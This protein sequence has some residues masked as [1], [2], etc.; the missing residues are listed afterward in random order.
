M[1]P[2]PVDRPIL[3]DKW[4]YNER[5]DVAAM[6]RAVAA[7]EHHTYAYDLPRT[8]GDAVHVNPATGA[9]VLGTDN[10]VGSSSGRKYLGEFFIPP[11]YTFARRLE[12]WVRGGVSSSAS[13]GAT[14]K[15][16]SRATGRVERA[17]ITYAQMNN[18]VAGWINFHIRAEPFDV[19]EVWI[20][21]NM[22][23]GTTAAVNG[24]VAWWEPLDGLR[25]DV[26]IPTTATALSQTYFDSADV[27]D[28][29]YQLRWLIRHANMFAGHRPR[30]VYTKWFGP[31]VATAPAGTGPVVSSSY[32]KVYV[33]DQISALWCRFLLSDTYTAPGY[34]LV[35]LYW[36]GTQVTYTNGSGWN[37]A[38]ISP[39]T[40]PG[41]NLNRGVHELRVDAVADAT[42]SGNAATCKAQTVYLEENGVS[43]IPLASGDAVPAGFQTIHD[44]AFASGLPMRR[45]I[46]ASGALAGPKALI[47]N[48][49]WLWSNRY[50]RSLVSDCRYHDGPG[51]G[52]Y[53]ITPLAGAQQMA[54]YAFQTAAALR[55]LGVYVHA[56]RTS[57]AGRAAPAA[58]D[59]AVTTSGYSTIQIPIDGATKRIGG[60]G[61]VESTTEHWHQPGR[62][63]PFPA[64]G[65]LLQINTLST[66]DAQTK[67]HGRAAGAVI[68]TAVPLALP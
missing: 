1:L 66:S 18:L 38:S 32:Y 34:A 23:D 39:S 31:V 12:V 49:Y 36:D 8:P 53:Q 11:S 33:G 13:A 67:N 10:L 54:Y 21:P 3:P 46:D 25:A 41:T 57:I 20:E 15:F 43:G 48:M 5:A 52:G 4:A 68:E 51:A 17:L 44:E 59:V 27:P 60:M 47:G 50:R 35:R 22:S 55:D 61:H 6:W 30:A 26:T 56:V 63:D 29:T 7:W 2:I 16:V 64:A 40:A 58:F 19:V 28:S 37:L 45:A 9:F 42:G 62:Y 14:L 65:F 24:I